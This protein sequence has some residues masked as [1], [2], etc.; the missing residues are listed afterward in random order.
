MNV[1]YQC[2]Y[3]HSITELA[4]TQLKPTTFACPQCSSVSKIN[5]VNAE[6]AG[7]LTGSFNSIY[8]S[9][10]E[11]ITYKGDVYFIVGIS[12]KRE[13]GSYVSWNEY[14]LSSK[15]GK[16]I[17]LAHGNDFNSFLR[18]IAFTPEME[19]QSKTGGS[20]KYERSGYDFD[21]A[22]YAEPVAAQGIFFNN[23]L[24]ESYNRTFQNDTHQS[25]F[26]SIEK[27]Q[28]KTEAFFGEY[29]NKTSFR[30]L[31]AK[32]REIL[33][34]ANNVLKNILLFAVLISVAVSVLHFLLNYNNL[35]QVS[36]TNSIIKNTTTV[37]QF[38][39]PPFEVRGHDKKVKFSFI[40]EVSN[41]AT[42]VSVSLVNERTNVTY[43]TETFQ[44]FFNMKN[45]ASGNEITF[46]NVNEGTYHLAFNYNSTSLNTEHSYDVDYKIMVGGVTL[47]WLYIIIIL[48]FVLT[49]FYNQK[50]VERND[51]EKLQSFKD[52][53]I[54]KN[55]EALKLGGLILALFIAGNYIFVSNLTCNSSKVNSEIENSTYTGNRVHYISNTYS[56][57]ASHK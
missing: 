12:T 46:C 21:F 37:T 20:L 41:P 6:Y 30:K 50:I 9:L 39:S 49:Y 19:Q 16:L 10:N 27:Y 17:F 3:C 18:E 56:S 23:I 13:K 25:R 45:Y 22:Q 14:I 48:L 55:K 34:K 15:E 31:F 7:K 53:L 40:S 24:E 28:D 1:K 33:Y 36:Y 29:L 57:G 4:F 52:L 2:D 35:N 44:H 38:I 11:T 5:G 54:Y 42:T 26:L 8:A 47:T 51:T 32:E 43:L